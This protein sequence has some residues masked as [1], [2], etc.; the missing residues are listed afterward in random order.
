MIKKTKNSSSPDKQHEGDL[1]PYRPGSVSPLFRNATSNVNESS[2]AAEPGTASLN[3]KNLSFAE[4]ANTKK[5]LI[6]KILKEYKQPIEN[7]TPSEKD[8]QSYEYQLKN[9]K[10][11][12][13]T[14]LNTIVS[15]DLKLDLLD[16]LKSLDKKKHAVVTIFNDNMTTDTGV[17]HCNA[18]TFSRNGMRYIVMSERGIYDPEFK[19]IHFYY[20]SNN[21]WPII[22]RKNKLPSGESDG[23][24][25]DDTI[26]MSVIE[27]LA[28]IN[29]SQKVNLVIVLL[30][31]VLVLQG[32]T[33]FLSLKASGLL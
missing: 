12:E 7:H 16:R 24:L 27:A 9:L 10:L 5:M 18:R 14:Y 31:F 2:F 4:K 29:V 32:I 23:T 28:Q 13:L 26:E 33:T 6:A 25:L 8:I 3:L 19:M 15:Y 20:Y 17:C 22:F 11:K 21:P 1:K 30:I